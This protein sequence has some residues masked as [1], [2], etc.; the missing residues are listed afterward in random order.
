MISRSNA[1]SACISPSTTSDG[2][3]CRNSATARERLS[4]LLDAGIDVYTTVNI[5]HV[6]SLNDIV[7]QIPGV[8][9]RETFDA[10]ST[11]SVEQQ[12]GG[13]Q[14]ILVGCLL[15]LAAPPYPRS[16]LV[17]PIAW[18]LIGTQANILVVN[19]D[20]PVH[21]LKEL[22]ALAKDPVPEV[23]M[24]V[25]RSLAP[26]DSEASAASLVSAPASANNPPA[27]DQVLLDD[28]FEGRRV[29]VFVPGALRIDDGHRPFAAHAQMPGGVQVPQMPSTGSLPTSLPSKDSLLEQ[30]KGM[31]AEDVVA[32]LQAMGIETGIDLDKLVDA[33]LLAKDDRRYRMGAKVGLLANSSRKPAVASRTIVAQGLSSE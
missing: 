13:W 9:V 27:A 28:A 25:A 24:A 1:V 10:E 6:E 29:A 20:V 26:Y 14:A 21:S 3:R 31:S 8:T 7:A 16:V 5:Q 12:R 19:P 22:I 18:S 4:V 33:G 32:M 15:A 11:H 23:R 30:A 17:A 2:S